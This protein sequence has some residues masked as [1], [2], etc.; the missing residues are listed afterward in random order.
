V[1][2]E[3]HLIVV[4]D[5]I[6]WTLCRIAANATTRHID[7]DNERVFRSPWCPYRLGRL[8]ANRAVVVVAV[9]QWGWGLDVV[10]LSIPYGTV[11]AVQAA[12]ARRHRGGD[13]TARPGTGPQAATPGDGSVRGDRPLED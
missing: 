5:R 3:N 12:P 7:G 4:I 2:T 6:A 9:F 11:L 13:G 10:G 1:T 8:C